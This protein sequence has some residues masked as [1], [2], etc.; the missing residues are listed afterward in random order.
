MFANIINFLYL[1]S[2][3]LFMLGIKYLSSPATA[4]RG[5]MLS[6]IGMAVAI[7]ITLINPSI[8]SYT[9][10]FL[11]VIIGTAIGAVA[12][13]RVKMTQMP[14]MVAV[15]NGCGGIASALVA[16]AE[17]SGHTGTIA[18]FTLTT[19]LLSM[20]VGALTFSG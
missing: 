8:G 9:L 15:F 14:E 6:A 13:I 1:V 11:G 10:I 4:K 7:L 2:A 17:F 18:P 3:V 19:L 16:L 5:N 20:I 12:A